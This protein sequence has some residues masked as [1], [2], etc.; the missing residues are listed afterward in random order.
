MT[1]RTVLAATNSKAEPCIQTWH[2]NLFAVLHRASMGSARLAALAVVLLVA[3]ASAADAVK[4]PGGF[5]EYAQHS[6]SNTP[7]RCTLHREQ[8]SQD[9]GNILPPLG[10]WGSLPVRHFGAQTMVFLAPL[11]SHHSPCIHATSGCPRP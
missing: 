5:V 9:Y 7:A 1:D 8:G 6:H 2:S 10:L 4:T 11:Q 3:V